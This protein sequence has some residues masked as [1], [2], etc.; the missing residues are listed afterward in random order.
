MCV[1]VDEQQQYVSDICL[2]LVDVLG[3]HLGHGVGQ[4]FTQQL[5]LD[6]AQGT[7][8]N[9]LRALH[10]FATWANS[11]RSCPGCP[12]ELFVHDGQLFQ[13][14]VICDYLSYRLDS[15]LSWSGPAALGAVLD[16][17]TASCPPDFLGT[18]QINIA[19]QGWWRSWRSLTQ[20]HWRESGKQ[21]TRAPLSSADAARLASNPPPPI[22][23]G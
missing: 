9:R 15:D 23:A 5:L 13:P 1:G 2:H 8:A 14:E 12:P 18:P 21:T 19:Q 4:R 22:R 20:R 17:V 3:A 6:K 7:V 16:A 11:T 10:E